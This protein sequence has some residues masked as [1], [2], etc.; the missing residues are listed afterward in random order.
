MENKYRK[1]LMAFLIPF[2]AGGLG[3]RY[4]NDFRYGKNSDY[5]RKLAKSLMPSDAI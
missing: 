1:I 3:K 5:I 4:A 2:A